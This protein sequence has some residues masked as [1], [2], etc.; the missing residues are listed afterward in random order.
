VR[1]LAVAK[2]TQSMIGSLGVSG[3]GT[4]AAPS[5]AAA[6][7]VAVAA[8][9]ADTSSA[10]LAFTAVSRAAVWLAVSGAD[11][12]SGPVSS[13]GATRADEASRALNG[14]GP[15]TM[16]PRKPLPPPPPPLLPPP[17]LRR[18]L[19]DDRRVSAATTATAAAWCEWY[20]GAAE[21]ERPREGCCQRL[22]SGVC[23]NVCALTAVNL[24]E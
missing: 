11:D 21:A 5:P 1:R 22:P 3:V 16:L 8:A 23:V 24:R 6:A 19:T 14:R 18:S 7:S 4:T 2:S 10:A 9:A 20:A 15:G 12:G 13:D 17:S